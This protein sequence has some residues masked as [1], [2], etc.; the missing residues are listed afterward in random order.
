MESQ[1]LA[2]ME[3]EEDECL[4]YSVSKRLVITA[5]D[6]IQ[7]ICSCETARENGKQR[8]LRLT[9][10]SVKYFKIRQLTLLQWK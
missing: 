7:Y 5:K 3:C 10:N 9:P 4:H 6:S 8:I 2:Q 1:R